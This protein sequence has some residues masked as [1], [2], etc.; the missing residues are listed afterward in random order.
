MTQV[1]IDKGKWIATSNPQAEH[2]SLFALVSY[3]MKN[4]G[5]FQTVLTTPRSR[6]DRDVLPESGAEAEA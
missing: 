5:G 6:T 3:H 4:T 1:I 2:A